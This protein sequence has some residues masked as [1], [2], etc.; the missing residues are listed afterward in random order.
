VG[1]ERPRASRTACAAC[2]ACKH[3]SPVAVARPA[4]RRSDVGSSLEQRSS[5]GAQLI[6]CAPAPPGRSASRLGPR[7]AARSLV[8][9]PPPA[10]LT[11][12]GVYD[13]GL[14]AGSRPSGGQQADL[15][16]DRGYCLALDPEEWHR[17]DW[18]SQFR[19]HQNW[20]LDLPGASAML[21]QAAANALDPATGVAVICAQAVRREPNGVVRLRP[22]AR[23]VPSC[24]N[25]R[26]ASGARRAS[27]RRAVAG[28]KRCSLERR[29]GA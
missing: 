20:S 29:A 21:G 26:V 10:G 2:G 13:A 5:P 1:A 7:T 15:R 16:R 19:P 9:M 17:S 18:T 24:G 22:T 25:G 4:K 14:L 8:L 12:A 23:A 6:G 27:V 11:A 28:A 3:G